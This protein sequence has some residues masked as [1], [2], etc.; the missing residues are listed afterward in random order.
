MESWNIRQVPHL[1][2]IGVQTKVLKGGGQGHSCRVSSRDSSLFNTTNLQDQQ[3]KSF[4]RS[5]E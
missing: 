3:Q 5:S 4:L 1:E 2:T